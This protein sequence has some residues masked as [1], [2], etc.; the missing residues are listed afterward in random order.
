MART[1]R[2]PHGMTANMMAIA[3]ANAVARQDGSHYG[4]YAASH[5]MSAFVA[6]RKEKKANYCITCGKEI[7]TATGRKKKYCDECYRKRVDRNQTKYYRLRA[8]G[9]YQ[10]PEV[11]TKC[12][13]CG[14]EVIRH[15]NPHNVKCDD[16]K[17]QQMREYKRAYYERKKIEKMRN[18]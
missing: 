16:C 9:E 10:K 5:D 12:S 13:A 1:Q 17:K 8:K 11:I 4:T 15:S 18:R 7:I 6:K 3:N 2:L 14:K